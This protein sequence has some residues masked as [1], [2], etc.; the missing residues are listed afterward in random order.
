M[1]STRDCPLDARAHH[2]LDIA[3]G[4]VGRYVFL[5]GDPGR[6]EPIAR[7]FD[8]PRKGASKREY[9]TWTGTLDGTP[10]SVTSTGIGGVSAA[11]SMEELAKSGTDTFIRVGTSGSMQERIQPVTW[12]WCRVRSATKGPRAALPAGRVPGSR[13]CGCHRGAAQR[14]RRHGSHRPRRDRTV[15]GL[16]HEQ[17]EPG[18]IPVGNQLKE[19]W[20][21]WMAGGAICSEMEAATLFTVTAVRS[22]RAGGIMLVAGSKEVDEEFADDRHRRRLSALIETA[23]AG[24]RHLIA[25]DAAARAH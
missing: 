8:D 20:Q 11:I 23:V 14:G 18:R 10:V 25:H 19:R 12:T 5:P 2:L 7:L 13:R 9:E 16:L 17:Y 1:G 21:A 24:L 22:L 4:D 15:E 3:A 6:C